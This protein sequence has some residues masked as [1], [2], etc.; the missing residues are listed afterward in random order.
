MTLSLPGC[1]MKEAMK[2]KFGDGKK[3]SVG[4]IIYSE[5][6]PRIVR[7]DSDT[8]QQISLHVSP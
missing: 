4:N 7:S 1:E 5:K 3:N 8:T 2:A 6:A